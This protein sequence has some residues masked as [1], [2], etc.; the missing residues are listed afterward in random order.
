MGKALIIISILV[1]AYFYLV[2]KWVDHE[3]ECDEILEKYDE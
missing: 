2:K 3:V 1:A